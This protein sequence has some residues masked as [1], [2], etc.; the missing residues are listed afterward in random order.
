MSLLNRIFG[1]R[2]S[3]EKKGELYSYLCELLGFAP[4]NLHYYE[5]AMTHRSVNGDSN[6]RLEFLGDAL[7]GLVI[8]DELYKMFPN[9][10]E[11]FLTRARSHVV[12]RD[13]LN[14]LAREIGIDKHLHTTAPLK[15]N[16]ENIF[17]NAFEALTGAIFLDAGYEAAASFVRKV[18]VG[19][20]GKI[21]QRLSEHETDFKSRLLEYAQSKHYRVEFV[22]SGERYEAETDRHVFV[23]DVL[24]DGQL[25]SQAAG[26][27]KREAQQIAAR[28]AL[29]YL[30]G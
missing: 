6:E 19:K 23:Y 10:N 2:L 21:L 9:E 14:K 3:G 26:Y 17:G 11:G 12:C 8:A 16:S 15:G 5:Q 7:M 27:S 29:K 18:L 4:K 28:K 22:Q 24:S 25:V 30:Q 13:N 20:D 1:I